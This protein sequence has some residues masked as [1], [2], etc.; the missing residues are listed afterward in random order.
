MS[1]KDL[2]V[3]RTHNG[4]H[5]VPLKLE[6]ERAGVGFELRLSVWRQE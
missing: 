1:L 4:G 3:V 6:Q 2:A 5:P